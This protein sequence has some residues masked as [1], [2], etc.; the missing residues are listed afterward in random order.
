MIVLNV[1]YSVLS[2]MLAAY[3]VNALV[4]LV[5]YLSGRHKYAQKL[6]SEFRPVSEAQWPMVTVQLPVYN[7]VDVIARLIKSACNLDYPA[8]KLQIQVV[9]DST[10]ETTLV[11][12]QLVK[13]YQ[14]RG[15]NICL[16]HRTNLV[17]FKVGA[18]REAL[19]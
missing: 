9:D 17:G 14:N 10:D 2:L 12:A 7:E 18:M 8:D 16:V 5:I 13:Q 4:L 6:R 11:A 19:K 1:T 15:V 3:V